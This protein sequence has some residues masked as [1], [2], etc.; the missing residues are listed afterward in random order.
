MTD[1]ARIIDKQTLMPLG[2]VVGCASVVVA[3]ILK[4]SLAF[5]DM[6]VAQRQ[7]TEAVRSNTLAVEDV[8][9]SLSDMSGRI[10][11]LEQWILRF[12]DINPDVKFPSQR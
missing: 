10:V 7:L 8:D 5:H 6:E 4:A 12:Q 2:V 3:V 9:G 1:Q 11:Q